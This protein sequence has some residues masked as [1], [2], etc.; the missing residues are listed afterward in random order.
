VV[1]CTECGA[2]NPA[3]MI[4]C[5][6]C[7]CPLPQLC[8]QCGFVNPGQTKFCGQCGRALTKS[9]S[10]LREPQ[11]PTQAPGSPIAADQHSPVDLRLQAQRTALRLGLGRRQLTVMFCDLVGSTALS[12]QVGL[13]ELREVIQAYHDLCAEV[14]ARFDGYVARYLG[15]GALVYFGFPV[16]HE[17]D[18]YRAVRAGLEIVAALPRL[19]VRLQKTVAALQASPLRVRIGIHT[20]P[21]VAGEVKNAG[22]RDLVEV[23]GEPL[24]LSARLQEIAEPDSVLISAATFQLVQGFFTCRELGVRAFKDVSTPLAVYLVEEEGEARSRLEVAATKGLSPLVGRKSQLAI[25]L[26]RWRNAQKGTGHIVLL[27]GEAGIGKS[28]LLQALREQ[29]SEEPH[30]WLEAHCFPYLQHSALHPTLDLLWRALNFKRT[31]SPTEKLDKLERTLE[32]YGLSPAETVPVFANWLG[33]PL[34]ENRYAPLSLPPQRQRRGVLEGLRVWL[35]KAAARRPVIGVVEDLQWADPS[36]LESLTLF[37]EQVPRAPILLVFTFRPDF[38]IPWRLTSYMTHLPLERLSDDEVAALSE[39][40]AHGR[41]LS[42]EVQTLLVKKADGV[43]LF[44]EELTKMM[45]ETGTFATAAPGLASSLSTIPTTLNDVLMARLDRSQAAK[46]IAQLGATIGREFSYELLQAVSPVDEDTLQLALTTLVDAELLYQRGIPP[47]ATYFFKHAL[48]QDVAYQSLRKRTQRHYHQQIAETLEARA[49]ELRE[50]QSEVI[51]HHYSEAQLFAP[52]IR[53]WQLAGQQAT[54]RSALAEAT[55]HFRT[56]LELMQR[57]PESNER[58]QQALA[59]QI[60]LGGPLIATQGY[61]SAAVEQCYGRALTLCRQIGETPRLLR[62]LF[63]LEAF[64]FIRA[65][66]GTAQQLAE[67]CLGLAQQQSQPGPL[68][69]A[70]WTLGQTFFHRGRFPEALEQVERGIALYTPELHQPR[71]LQDPGVMCLAYAAFA[72]WSLG[73]PERAFQHGQRMLT[74][75]RSLRHRF[76]LAFALNIAATLH[77]LRGEISAAEPLTT[78][79]ITLSKEYGFPMWTAYG[80]VLRGWIRGQR[81]ARKPAW[82]ELQQGMKEW[83]A[84][85]AE[86]TRTAFLALL[87]HAH[88]CIGQGNEARKTVDQA[89]HLALQHEEFYGITELWRLKGELILRKF[90]VQGSR[91]KVDNPQSENVDNPQSTIRLPP[92]SGGNPQLEAE[93]CFHRALAIARQQQ[94]K[95]F[96]LRAALSLSRLWKRQG[97]R[98]AARQLLA[99]VYGKFTEGFTIPDLRR[100]QVMLQQLKH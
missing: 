63:G 46:E 40:V 55:H 59:L 85:G 81:A 61:G 17:G 18:A 28:R 42:P 95:T 89:L 49:A 91:F 36:T 74:L 44:V 88:A 80:K 23:V 78:E 93:E 69:Q 75:A 11:R 30:T 45:V 34:P 97:K 22:S 41:L 16:A 84:T 72:Q 26:D 66:L 32:A 96:E 25:L 33:L 73:Y 94:T 92:P 39:H 38:H 13:E 4:F 35:T 52:A 87:G 56:A 27:G 57:L 50:A 79:V 65:Q 15:D 86:V 29:V 5:G 58:D 24:A 48:I 100:A 8:Q 14:I 68:V 21:V 20:G 37:M 71:A 64:Y 3:G 12:Q 98:D 62:T 9:A 10:A 82:E 70:Y 51:A 43:P 7:A 83:E 76:S 67:Q 31:D 2:E 47:Q 1:Q 19:N 53:Y 6:Q 90:K 99:D 54:D 77:V 60:A